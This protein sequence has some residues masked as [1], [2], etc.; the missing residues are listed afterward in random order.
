MSLCK[1]NIEKISAYVDEAL[2]SAE[3]ATLEQHLSGCEMCQEVLRATRRGKDLMQQ[4]FSPIKAP[5]HLM[6]RVKSG[7]KEEARQDAARYR[8]PFFRRLFA[9]SPLWAAASLVLVLIAGT[10]YLRTEGI[11]APGGEKPTTVGL[12]LYD[13][14][15]DQYLVDSLPKRPLDVECDDAAAAEAYMSNQVGF[16]VHIP[17]LAEAG[18]TMQGARL[19]HTVARISALIEYRD[20]SGNQISLF[21][22]KGERIGKSGG[23]R[24][25]A[26]GF[27]F[28]LGDAFGYNGVVWMQH[29]VALGL[30]ADLPHE[31]LV[32]LAR[33]AAVVLDR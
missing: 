30:V 8:V 22:I 23:K 3:R 13:I 19:W 12:Y 27:T 16:A 31:T 18:Y 28:Y 6:R 2:E 24:V 20:D 5:A 25:E 10:M 17:D 32:A 9:P 11:I 4:T 33:T 15:H 21:E 14:A 29:E 1:E 7:I 26:D